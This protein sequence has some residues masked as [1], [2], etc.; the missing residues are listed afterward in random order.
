MHLNCIR[1]SHPSRRRRTWQRPV[2][3]KA[4]WRVFALP[5]IE[6][7]P[8]GYRLSCDRPGSIGRVSG[9]NGNFSVLVKALAY[10]LSLG[11]DGLRA[12]SEAAVLHANYMMEALRDVLDLPYEGPCMHEFVASARSLWER[13]GCSALDVS[14]ML[15]DRGMHPP[16]MYFPLIVPEALMF[17][18]TETESLETLDEAVAAVREIA[19]TARRDPEALH[20]AP[21]TTPVGRL[22]EVEAARHPVVKYAFG[23]E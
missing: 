21:R 1:R 16:T 18:P 23:D 5:V 22:D 12:A 15:L 17:E 10:I 4:L 7:T 9:F 19:D 20:R 11:G 14:K 13:T 8:D 6:R 3:C 2:G